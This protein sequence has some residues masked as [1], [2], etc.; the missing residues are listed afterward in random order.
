MI[1]IYADGSNLNEMIE[2]KFDKNISGFTTN[3]S[4]MKKAG[5]TDYLKF[6]KDATNSIKTKPI[7]FEVFSDDLFEMEKQAR[8]LS[9]I[10]PNIYVK[11]PITNTKGVSTLDLVSVLEKDGIKVNVTALLDEKSIE[12]TVDKLR[13][14]LT[15]NI[16]SIFCG[17]IAD[18]G[19]DP[20]S[21]VQRALWNRG[22]NT[23]ILWASPREVYNLYQ[24]SACGCDI[25]TMS[26]DLLDKR[27]LAHYSLQEYSLD[28]VKMFY[29]DAKAAGYT[30]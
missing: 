11:I 5:V 9:S 12:D 28:T 4:L 10:A 23:K 19:R 6:V 27:K 14:S 30:L 29:N 1:E 18:T 7:S 16:V 2:L 24:A 13:R 20:V 25:I 17:R 15:P 3:P 21:F 22:P 8:L 26:K